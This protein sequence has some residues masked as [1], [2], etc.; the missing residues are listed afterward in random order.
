MQNVISKILSLPE[1]YEPPYDCNNGAWLFLYRNKA[2]ADMD[3]YVAD[4]LAMGYTVFDETSFGENY[5]TTMV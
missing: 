2:K 4:A 5:Y 3:S 1:G